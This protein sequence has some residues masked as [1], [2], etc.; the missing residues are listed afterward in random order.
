MG[1][2]QLGHLDTPKQKEYIFPTILTTHSTIQNNR[3]TQRW[4]TLYHLL[5][6]LRDTSEIGH[7]RLRLDSKDG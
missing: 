3:R 1:L 2:G 4:G 6:N 5:L 7:L